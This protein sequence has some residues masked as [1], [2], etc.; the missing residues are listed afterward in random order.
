MLVGYIIVV[1]GLFVELKTSTSNFDV[2][3][4]GTGPIR[5]KKLYRGKC[6]PT[7]WSGVINLHDPIPH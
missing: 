7:S 2:A 1:H 6:P 4:V 3:D 5:L